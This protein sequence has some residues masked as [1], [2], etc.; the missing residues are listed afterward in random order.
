MPSR[1]L[2]TLWTGLLIFYA[3]ISAAGCTLIH[4]RAFSPLLIFSLLSSVTLHSFSFIISN[5]SFPILTACFLLH[6]ENWRS[7]K[8]IS[9][10]SHT[11]YPRVSICSHILMPLPPKMLLSKCRL[12][13]CAPGLTRSLWLQNSAPAFSSLSY[14]INSS[15]F[16]GLFPLAQKCDLMSPIIKNTKKKG[17][18][19]WPSG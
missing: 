12:S 14:I 6:W 16:T 18:A 9:A 5:T 10:H 11:L 15:L 4:N 7:Q 17:P 3:E 13:S 1:Q 8:K 19:P 2:L